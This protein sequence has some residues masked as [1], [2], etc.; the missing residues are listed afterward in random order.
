MFLGTDYPSY[1]L[2]DAHADLIGMYEQMVQR[3]ERIIDLVR[4]LFSRYAADEDTREETL[5]EGPS[6]R[7][8][9]DHCLRNKKGEPGSPSFALAARVS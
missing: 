9:R 2:P 1:L 8:T 5:R 6:Q 7:Y 4:P 3:P